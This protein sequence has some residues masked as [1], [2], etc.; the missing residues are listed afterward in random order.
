MT[1]EKIKTILGH[2]VVYE[3]RKV[4]IEKLRFRLSHPRIYFIGKREK[5]D[6]FWSQEG[7]YTALIKKNHVKILV[8]DILRHESVVEPLIVQGKIVQGKSYKVLEGNSRLAACRHILAQYKGEQYQR[9]RENI[10]K[11]DCVILDE[12][13]PENLLF[14]LLAQY[15][16]RG[17]RAWDPYEKA[18]YALR[19]FYDIS[20]QQSEEKSYKQV[21]RE[22]GM[23]LEEV[24]I[25]CANIRM[26]KKYKETNIKRYSYYNV[27]NSDAAVK[28][29]IVHNYA[30]EE[31]I[32]E[33][34]RNH[35]KPATEFRSKI[36]RVCKDER[37]SRLFFEEGKNLEECI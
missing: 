26:M 32:V 12:K 1:V 21:A 2:S 37:A 29:K 16:L 17:K 11:I 33:T 13:T 19:R 20:K 31:R 36:T 34:I 23:S 35:S 6:N 24:M 27:V 4:D 28:A 3:N 8:K 7:I 22:I 25:L 10:K 30:N 15:H 18:D 5:N 14:S 9:V